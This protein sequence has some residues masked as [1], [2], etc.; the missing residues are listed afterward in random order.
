VTNPIRAIS[1]DQPII[2]AAVLR[3]PSLA[4]I[5]ITLVESVMTKEAPALYSMKD[6]LK[7]MN[8]EQRSESLIEHD[9]E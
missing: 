5:R 8:D 3:A 9:E 7:N 4:K 1:A 2:F 6:E